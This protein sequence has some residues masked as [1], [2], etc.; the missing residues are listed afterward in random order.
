MHLLKY[1]PDAM[2]LTEVPP[3]E[4][5]ADPTCRYFYV[6][7]KR[8]HVPIVTPDGIG[9]IVWEHPSYQPP[10]PANQ[11]RA[12]KEINGDDQ[13]VTLVERVAEHVGHFANEGLPGDEA[14]PIASAVLRDVA[15]WINERELKAQNDP[16]C[17]AAPTADE[18]V[19]WLRNEADR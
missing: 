13:P 3:S 2:T 12:T 14:K 16:Y 17:L 5:A 8:A 6:Q 11:H 9:E 10:K 1:N 18:V 19:G 7:G 4:F 15:A